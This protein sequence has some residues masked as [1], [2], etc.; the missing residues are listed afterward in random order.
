MF[1][2]DMTLDRNLND[3]RKARN[4]HKSKLPVI[5]NKNQCGHVGGCSK[6]NGKFFFLKV[7]HRVFVL[8]Q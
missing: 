7:G 4:L 5:S 6:S 8:K 3:K 2:K 1:L